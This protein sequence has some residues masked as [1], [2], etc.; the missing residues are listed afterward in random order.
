M[1]VLLLGSTGQVGK[2]LLPRL[3]EANY[4]V[5]AP[6]RAELDLY[7]LSAVKNFLGDCSPNL[8]INAAAYTAVDKAETEVENAFKL[9]A[10]LPETLAAFCQARDIP[11]I[12][13]STDY[14][15]DG[16]GEKPWV[17]TDPVNPLSV[18]GKSKLAGDNAL[19]SSRCK[20]VIFRTSWVYSNHGKNFLKTMLHLAKS[21]EQLTIVDDQLGVPTSAELIADVTIYSIRERWLYERGVEIINLC[22]NGYCSWAEFA[23]AIFSESA[24]LS[25][26]GFDMIP[27]VLGIPTEQYP[28]AAERPKN[29]VL[30]NQKLQSLTKAIAIK[31]WRFYMKEVLK[32]ELLKVSGEKI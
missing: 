8:I 9:N 25:C 13:Y 11:L 6:T 16:S 20:A 31:N 28:T 24:R 22:P 23:N 30:N 2:E 29:S 17:E 12:H 32:K 10:H 21:N 3:K 14:V 4:E 27:T 19:Q 1:K 18:Y 5:I 15:Y 26:L 7:E